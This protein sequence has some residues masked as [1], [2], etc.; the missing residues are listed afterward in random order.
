MS[1]LSPRIASHLAEAAYQTLDMPEH[2]ALR[3]K[4]G[5]EIERFFDFDLSNGPV[6]GVL[7][8]FLVFTKR[9]QASL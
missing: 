5:P 2:Q 3:L 1:V 7:A 6:R 8:A 9:R 4:L